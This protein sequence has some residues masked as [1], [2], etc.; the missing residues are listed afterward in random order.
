[1]SL[2]PDANPRFAAKRIRKIAYEDGEN[3][4]EHFQ[5][6]DPMKACRGLT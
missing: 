3:Q 4:E 5:P 1:L 2:A 6:V